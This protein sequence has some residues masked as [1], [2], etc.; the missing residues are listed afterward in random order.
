MLFILKRKK[1]KKKKASVTETQLANPILHQT[2]KERR[3]RR[4]IPEEGPVSEEPYL[5]NF[6]K[7]IFIWQQATLKNLLSGDTPDME[8]Q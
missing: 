3:E 2:G 4:K 5:M 6:S 1:G 8:I 7:V